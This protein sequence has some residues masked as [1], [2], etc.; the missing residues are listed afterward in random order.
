MVT[1]AKSESMGAPWTR[2]SCIRKRILVSFRSQVAD[3]ETSAGS[4][5][6]VQ[7][8]FRFSSDAFPFVRENTNAS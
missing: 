4:G 5:G 8:N 3:P 7:V 6:S 2:V 1:R